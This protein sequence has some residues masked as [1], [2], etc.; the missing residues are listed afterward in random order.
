MHQFGTSDIGTNKKWQLRFF[1]VKAL[2]AFGLMLSILAISLQTKNSVALATNYDEP[3]SK[4]SSKTGF[5]PA[6]IKILVPEDARVEIKIEGKTTK[7]MGDE[8]IFKTPELDPTKTYSYKIESIIEPNNYT[9]IFRNREIKFKAGET[10][11]VDIRKKDEKIKD[12]VRIRWV[13]TPPDIAKKMGEMA[14]IKENDIVYDLGCGDGIMLITAL[15]EFRAKKGVGVDIDPKRITEATQA[16][17]EA[18][19]TNR[20]ELR[21]GNILEVKDISDANV[22]LLYLGDEMNIRLRPMLLKSLKPGSRIVSHRFTMGDWKPDQSLT[23]KGEDGDEYEL[24]LWTIK[25]KMDIK[26]KLEKTKK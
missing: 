10:V 7:Q 23:V 6:I 1:R 18:G 4:D 26:D 13:P 11:V 20:I 16:A 12:D 9:K 24:H 15:K 3:S 21:K 14:K 2:I 5:K 22:V 19:V 25:E 8:R 17:K